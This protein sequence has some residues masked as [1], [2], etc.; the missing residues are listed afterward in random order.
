MDGEMFLERGVVREECADEGERPVCVGLGACEAGVVRSPRGE[1][2][3]SALE[4]KNQLRLKYEEG[5]NEIWHQESGKVGKSRRTAP[6]PAK[7]IVS[8]ST[9]LPASDAHGTSGV[10]SA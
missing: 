1:A 10:Y 7:H 8:S 6:T 3:W 9:M 5:K 2:R 4:K